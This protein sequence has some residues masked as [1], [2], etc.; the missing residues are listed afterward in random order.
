MT[1]KYQ[2]LIIKRVNHLKSMKNFD[3][4]SSKCLNISLAESYFESNDAQSSNYATRRK[5]GAM[6]DMDES[7][8][9]KAPKLYQGLGDDWNEDE[10][11]EF[12]DIDESDAE[13]SDS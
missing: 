7:A 5:R 8:N 4:L 3:V 6:D 1:A 2:S 9:A 12:G 10:I 13:E 11:E